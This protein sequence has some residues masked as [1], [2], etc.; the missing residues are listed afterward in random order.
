M[1][2]LEIAKATDLRLAIKQARET[3]DST[4]KIIRAHTKA[5]S[6]PSK[7]ESLKKSASGKVNA[8]F[9]AFNSL[10]SAV[11]KRIG[12]TTLTKTMLITPQVVDD[13]VKPYLSY[14]GAHGG[15]ESIDDALA[16]IEADRE[17]ELKRH[18]HTDQL[19]AQINE[20]YNLQREKYLL[21]LRAV[22]TQINSMVQSLKY[23]MPSLGVV[24]SKQ[25][26]IQIEAP[27]PKANKP[28]KPRK[29]E[30]VAGSPTKSATVKS[31]VEA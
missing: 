23:E 9:K 1:A 19:K 17:K 7:I 14:L 12:N 8:I 20:Y 25:V 29:K 4:V 6:Y 13:I 18:G 3:T 30:K 10:N 5:I 11:V 16:F 2:K 26:R 28:R 24:S 15:A 21:P 22:E 31:L 27:K